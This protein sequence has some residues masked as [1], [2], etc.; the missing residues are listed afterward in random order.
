MP[1][2]DYRCAANGTVHEV[3]HSIHSKLRSWKE[4]CDAMGRDPGDVPLDAPVERLISGG[5]YVRSDA[6]KNPELPA[7]GAEGACG[8]GMCGIG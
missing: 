8:G 1:T 2:Y 3:Q 7:C 5:S 6:L 4:L